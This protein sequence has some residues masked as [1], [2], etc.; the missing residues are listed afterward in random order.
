MPELNEG[1]DRLFFLSDELALPPPPPPRPPPPS[2]GS[3]TWFR[4]FWYNSLNRLPRSIYIYK[5]QMYL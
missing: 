4:S 5:Y 2:A 1:R 3:T